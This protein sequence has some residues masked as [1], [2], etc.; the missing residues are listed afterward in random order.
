MS[1][2][3]IIIMIFVFLSVFGGGTYYIAR[4]LYKWMCLLFPNMNSR[5]AMVIYTGIFV[6]LALS[7]I[8][9]FLR[10]PFGIRW[11]MHSISSYWIGIFMYLVILFVIADIFI[12]PLK[13]TNILQG[14]LL[15]SVRL[16]SGLAVVILT[17][18]LVCCGIINANFIKTVNYEI[19]LNDV[20][21]NN[22]KI[23]LISDTHLGDTNSEKNLEKIVKAIND[24]NADIV[25]IAGDIFL[26]DYNII[27]NP[28]RAKNLFRSIKS[29]YGVYA[30][31][32][33]HDGGNTLNQMMAFLEESNIKLL[34]D[35][36]VIIDDRFA[37]FG[38]LDPH[39]IGGTGELKRSDISAAISSVGENFAVIVMDHNPAN[40]KEYG[41]SV[42]LILSGHTHK[43]QMF[44]GSLF[45]N[46]MFTAAYGHYQK[47]SSSPH[48]IVTSGSSTWRPPIRIG[49][50]NEI[51]VIVVR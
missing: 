29:T 17:T 18:G 48:V 12:I 43:G 13:I 47:D 32:G 36:Y 19:Q 1:I 51:A 40:I 49:S 38:R 44:P 4:R 41:Q 35:E 2:T 39:P 9:G 45:T 30:C 23:V 24:Q 42:D 14:S 21:L 11:I 22:L 28:E 27:R 3:R 31:L 8:L 34:K 46:A 7:V 33:N 26:D 10:L 20:S 6:F 15:T 50:N 5:H 25:C 16:Y 37:L